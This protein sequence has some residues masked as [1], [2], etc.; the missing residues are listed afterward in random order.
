MR[1][2]R[3]RS[4]PILPAGYSRSS[5]GS[6]TGTSAACCFTRWPPSAT[7]LQR[8]T[9]ADRSTPPSASRCSTA[10]AGTSVTSAFTAAPGP[11]PRA[12]APGP[13][14]TTGPDVVFATG[15]YAPQTREGRTVIAHELAHVVQ[16]REA[17]AADASGAAAGGW[18]AGALEQQAKSASS[19]AL[20]GRDVGPLSPAPA[21]SVQALGE[22][23]APAATAPAPAAD[24][25]KDESLGPLDSWAADQ[26]AGRVIGEPGWTFFREM[27]R[28]FK[29]GIRGAGAI[30]AGRADQMPGVRELPGIYLHYLLGPRQ[31]PRQ[32][33]H[34]PL[35]ACEVRRR[36]QLEVP[37]VAIRA[38]IG[39][40]RFGRVTRRREDRQEPGR[41]RGAVRQAGRRHREEPQASLYADTGHDGLR[42]GLR[43]GDGAFARPQGSRGGEG[44]PQP[45]MGGD[46]RESR[47]GDRHAARAGPDD[48]LHC[49]DRQRDLCHRQ[50]RGQGRDLGRRESRR[51][52]PLPHGRI[53]ES[54]DRRRRNGGQGGKLFQGLLSR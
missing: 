53:Q 5:R 3:R 25:D 52:A 2:R 8:P 29:G 41:A 33:D 30:V 21:G 7:G 51:T 35:P 24:P 40:D 38:G 19:A 46:G 34:R 32:P 15:E 4:R 13:P 37:P 39:T 54:H 18:S 28:G 17:G 20:A 42:H 45:S 23:K 1:S 22:N 9:A 36:A 50:G 43:Q 16:Q 31:R 44:L 14:Y 49:G 47:R 11:P 12:F 26:T 6:A 10:S 48:H 27:L